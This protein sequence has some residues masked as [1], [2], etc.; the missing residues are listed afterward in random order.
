M[1]RIFR[2]KPNV[3]QGFFNY[4]ALLKRFFKSPH[5]AAVVVSDGRTYRGIYIS[6]K[7]HN[8]YRFVNHTLILTLSVYPNSGVSHLEGTRAGPFFIQSSVTIRTHPRLKP[9]Q[10]RKLMIMSRTTSALTENH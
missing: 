1:S 6:T 8:G 10:H 2:L 4:A 7:A 3:V 5:Q 9:A